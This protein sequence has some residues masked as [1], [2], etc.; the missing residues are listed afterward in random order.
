[1]AV[2][3]AG[4]VLRWIIPAVAKFPKTLRYGLGAR[5]EGA[6]TDV[7]EGLVVAQDA[8]GSHRMGALPHANARLQV[9]ASRAVGRGGAG[10]LA[11][12]GGVRGGA[13]GAAREAGGGMAE[14]REPSAAFARI[15]DPG[16]IGCD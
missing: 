13:D 1:V 3:L 4:D 2:I 8:T 6:L 5:I 7:L 10:A 16:Q 12:A 15:C 9:A 14:D 11:A